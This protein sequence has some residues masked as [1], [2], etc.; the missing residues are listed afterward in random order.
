M[1]KLALAIAAALALSATAAHARDNIE[2]VGSSTV[3]PFTTAAAEAFAK[4][5]GNPAPKVESTGTG[6]GMKLFCAGAGVQTP[7]MTNA[8][9][10]M[11]KSEFDDCKKNGVDSIT[12]ILMGYDGLAVA[13]NKTGPDFKNFGLKDLFLGLAKN[14]PNEAGELVPNPYKMWSD[15]NPELPAIKIEVIGPPPTS[16]TR[17]SFVELGLEGGCKQIDALKAL[18]EKDKKAFETACHTIREDGGY[19]E[20]GENDNLIVQKLGTNANALGVFGFSYL[21]QNTDVLRGL[22]FDGVNP[23]TES[24][25][26]GTY[27]MARSMFIY[28]K[29]AHVDQVKGLKEYVAEYVSEDAM[30]TD[31]YMVDK[32]LVPVAASELPEIAKNATSFTAMKGDDLK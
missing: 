9:R 17:D 30:G 23:T 24:V 1:K 8:S 29:N 31:G 5:T 14:V 16:G 25:I 7:D 6:G 32:G 19:I 11:K 10:R 12:E 4:K 3:Y 15:V 18:K 27:P 26:D 2:I 28:V 20:G 13:Q 22:S 21:N